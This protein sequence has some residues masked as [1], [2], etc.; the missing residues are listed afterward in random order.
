MASRGGARHGSIV[1]RVMPSRPRLPARFR[2]M[3]SV[4]AIEHHVVRGQTWSLMAGGAGGPIVG[5]PPPRVSECRTRPC[6]GRVA[7][8][9]RAWSRE[10]IASMVR[11]C[12]AQ[13]RRAL[14]L[15]SVA[16][17][18][19]GRGHGGTDVAEIA[20]YGNVRAGQGEAGGAMVKN[21]ARPGSR[22]MARVACL[23][24]S[25]DHMVWSWRNINR[26][27]GALIKWI[28][29]TVASGRQRSGIVTVYVALRA[30][31]SC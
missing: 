12:P 20:G 18:T 9:T 13:R 6:R 19:V 3:A 11:H 14:P 22:C 8:R 31:N 29:A 26:G 16:A 30:G 23:W 2:R 21:R 27:G 15:S 1:A 4:D 25:K 28:V 24:I 5:N 10:T 17:V 7:G